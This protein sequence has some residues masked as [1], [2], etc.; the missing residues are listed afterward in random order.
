MRVR[1]RA[2]I[3]FAVVIAGAVLLP[4][5]VAA[6]PHA[7]QLRG[8]LAAIAAG[9][10]APEASI[11]S[12]S[13]AG[14]PEIAVSIDV[15]EAPDARTRALLR[16]AG[17]TVRGSWRTTIE[18]FI[19]PA[20][21]AELARLD[22]VRSITPIRRPLPTFV[23]P[24]P[25][26]HG[27]TGWQQAGYG[28]AG[29]KI[30]ILDV[31][32]EGFA[33]LMGSELPAT[34]EARC[35]AQLGIATSNLADCVTPGELH[36]TSVAESIIDMAPAASLYVSNAESPADMAATIGWMTAAGVRIINFSRASSILLE[37]MGDGTSAY[38][39]STYG[40]VDLAV[41]GGALF[42][43]S[44][45]NQALSSWMG[46]AND[47]NA[48]GWVDFAPGD[49]ADYLDLDAGQ[50]VAAVLRWGS[51]A[52]DYDLSIWQGDSKLAESADYQS[53]TGDPAELV[54]FT[55]PAPGRYE[56]SISRDSGPVAPTLR[57]MVYGAAELT[58]H[59]A[60]GS[61]PTP[62]DSRNPGVV[63]VGAVN[64]QSPTV[65]EPYSSRGP[66]ADGRTK[67][68]IVA[69]DCSATITSPMFCGTS[70]AAPFVTGAAALLVQSNPG[71]TPAQLAQYLKSHATSIGSPV[72]N[73]D[74]GF[75]LLALGPSPTAA[76]ASLAFLAPAASG[77][78]GAPLLGQPAVGI[79]DASG[80][81]LTT[82][83]GSSLPV[84]L[85]VAT[86]PSGGTLTCAAALTA[87]AV[88]GVARFSACAIDLAGSGYTLRADAAGLAG[89]VGA[90]FA[91]AAAGSPATLTLTSSA[92]SV[93]YGSAI[94]LT[95]QAALP[96][97]ALIAVEA[98][99]IAG[100]LDV[101]ARAGTTDAAGLASWTFKP[102]VTS[103]Y[104]LRTIAPGT[105]LVDV[106][107]PVRVRVNATAKLTSSIAT[108]RTISRTTRITLTT[109]IRPIGTLVARGRARFDVFQRTSAGWTRRST[110]YAN[111]DA[112]GRG[113]VTIRLPSAGSWWIRSRAEPTATNGAST[114]ATGVRYTV[115]R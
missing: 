9:K 20:R 51:A 16:E 17:L 58:Y 68:D 115:T 2:S 106:S 66:T 114:W 47:A 97:G 67:P 50:E 26:I 70:Q 14:T 83:P 112:T 24:A 40:L 34:V 23:G 45:G 6:H 101:E 80:Q 102:I 111:A 35:Y 48:N 82:G 37:G 42:V 88:G 78:A 92:G 1:R 38:P 3:C 79:L 93:T 81:L 36:G 76:P 55:A 29:V 77:V 110:V 8:G 12:R 10:A 71:A 113:R 104:R 4:L 56:I 52:S 63:T 84:T 72:P 98:V 73:N 33:G 27:A 91:V 44:A 61:L 59:T 49:E 30:G 89:A 87:V 21:L 69:V 5:P 74:S 57:L 54:I 28:G 86:N 53:A 65:V 100:G 90:P 32:F 19:A 95:G 64:Y 22:G 96:G 39:D 18:G 85:S 60:N 75:G 7:G 62:A 103:D 41:S 107:A 99:R 43:A 31:G 94:N 46:S 13:H 108:G 109:T 11:E 15:G 25:A 105:G